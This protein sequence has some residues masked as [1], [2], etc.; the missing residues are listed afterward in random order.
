M[1]AFPGQLGRLRPSL[2][3]GEKPCLGLRVSFAGQ[4]AF[5]RVPLI[6]SHERTSLE[7]PPC[8]RLVQIAVVNTAA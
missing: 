8:V 5:R 1:R 7:W 3:H 2:G 6:L 4:Q